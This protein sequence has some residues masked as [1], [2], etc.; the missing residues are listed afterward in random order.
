MDESH[1]AQ[2]LDQQRA[3][4]QAAKQRKGQRA[5]NKISREQLLLQFDSAVR[6]YARYALYEC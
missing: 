1:L 2:F 3:L 5:K 4:L 6:R